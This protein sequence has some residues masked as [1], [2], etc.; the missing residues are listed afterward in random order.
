MQIKLHSLDG[1]AND[2]T[3]LKFIFWLQITMITY[4]VALSYSVIGYEF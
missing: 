3:Q 1:I 2:Y 4:L